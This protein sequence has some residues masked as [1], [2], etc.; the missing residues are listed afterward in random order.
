MQNMD[1]NTDSAHCRFSL[2]YVMLCGTN[3]LINILA[4][5][6]VYRLALLLCDCLA[7]FLCH[8]LAPL[9]H[10]RVA[11]LIVRLTICVLNT[12]YIPALSQSCISGARLAVGGRTG[13]WQQGLGGGGQQQ[14]LEAG[15]RTHA[16][17]VSKQG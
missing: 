11:I 3:F 12:P 8:C 4:L 1:L 13:Q 16:Q 2:P 17:L 7:I 10:H 6:S 9:V 14:G 15:Q 5:L